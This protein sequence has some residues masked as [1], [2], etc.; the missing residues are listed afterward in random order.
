MPKHFV[1]NKDESPP[2]FHNKFLDLFSRVHWSVPLFVFVPVVLACMYWG[3]VDYKLGWMLLPWFVGGVLFWSFA[4]Y[5]LHRFV[6]HYEPP[7]KL[8]EQIHFIV[9]G[10][11]HDYPNDS[12]RLVMPPVLGI[13]LAIL[14]Y[15]LFTYFLGVEN[16]MPFFAGFISGYLVYDMTHYALHHA[17]IKHPYWKKLKEHHMVHHY[18]DPE[19]GYGVS[20]DF[21]DKIFRTEFNLIKRS[22]TVDSKRVASNELTSSE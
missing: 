13:P 21:W 6:F 17:N 12:L 18:H 3:M 5:V 7:G 2:L 19:N 22:K 16:T 8:G 1:S 10:V 11:H 20:S 15:Y 4:E 14:F 9:H